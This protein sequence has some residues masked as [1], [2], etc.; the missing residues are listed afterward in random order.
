M[1]EWIDTNKK[2]MILESKLQKPICSETGYQDSFI[3]KAKSIHGEKYD[4]SKV[5]YVKA[6]AKVT[7]ICKEHGAFEQKPNSHLSG[8]GCRK[9]A[10]TAPSTTDEFLAKAKVVHG[11][12]Y[13]YSKVVYTGNKKKV[14]II[15][16]NHG[17]FEQK[18]NSHLN[19]SGCRSCGYSTL[20]DKFK[21]QQERVIANFIAIHGN[22][23][24]YSK[25]EYVNSKQKVIVTCVTHGDFEIA[26]DHHINRKQGCAKCYYEAMRLTNEQFIEKA[27]AIYGDKYDYS[28][29]RYTT[30]D[31][32]VEI[33]CPTHGVFK[34]L[35][36]THLRGESCHKCSVEHRTFDNDKFITKAKSVHGDKYSYEN[37]AYVGYFK[38]V[39]ITCEKHGNFEQ[40]PS[41]HIK[42]TGCSKCTL[43]GT[44]NDCIYIWQ[45]EG[46]Y[47]L[48]L[49]V[50]KIG[51]T[52][53]RLDD[54]QRIQQVTKST[55]FK[56]ILIIK[57][58]VNN[59]IQLER[60]ILKMGIQ[61]DLGKCDG[62]T[63]FRAFQPYEFDNAL[64]LI[65]EAM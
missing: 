55:G 26:P 48:G 53:Q 60:E 3:S 43:M 62:M 8:A 5:E 56:A 25:V 54:N 47:H 7:I 58:P 22:N 19:G 29:T 42:G 18:P 10:G 34:Q 17:A 15:C 14:T 50:Y 40:A 2:I 65:N 30:G 4:Y 9:C 64:I 32:K 1:R 28:N 52:S 61:P 33:F 23:Y 63:E 35:A 31:A 41:D 39:S 12:R 49:P 57:K 24:D 6:L 37:V 27:K 46:I 13:D 45:A 11:D 59:A 20:S 21:H 44:D 36:R 16:P 38:K 51:V